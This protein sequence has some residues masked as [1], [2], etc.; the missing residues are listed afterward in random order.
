MQ[1]AVVELTGIADRQRQMHV[2]RQWESQ[3]AY[4]FVGCEEMP[5]IPPRYVVRVALGAVQ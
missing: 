1:Q 3:L 2:Q 5:P 4:E